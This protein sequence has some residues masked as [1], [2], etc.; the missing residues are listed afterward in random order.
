[1]AIE[2]LEEES[3]ADSIEHSYRRYHDIAPSS[4]LES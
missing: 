2:N 3:K 4:P 1:M